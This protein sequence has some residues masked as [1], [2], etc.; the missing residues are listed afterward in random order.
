MCYDDDDSYLTY[1]GT[2][3]CVLRALLMECVIQIGKAPKNF[4][5]LKACKIK[6]YRKGLHPLTCSM[7]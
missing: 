2:C 4:K 3:L 5:L 7:K 6:V 1:I